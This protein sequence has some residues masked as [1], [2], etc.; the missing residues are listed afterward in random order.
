MIQKRNILIIQKY[1]TSKWLKFIYLYLKEPKTIKQTQ[2][3]M[4]LVIKLLNGRMLEFDVEPSFQII[5]LKKKLEESEGID[6][7]QQRLVFGGKQLQDTKTLEELKIKNG[8][9]INMLL[10]LRGGS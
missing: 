2:K 9:T 7:E 10:A 6:A 4:K 1:N 5:D 8:V 3:E